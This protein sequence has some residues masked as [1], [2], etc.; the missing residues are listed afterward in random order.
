MQRKN[1]MKKQRGSHRGR[2]WTSCIKQKSHS[3]EECLMLHFAGK[4]QGDC[5]DVPSPRLLSAL[6]VLDP[7]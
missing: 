3:L 7:N 5:R 6:V 4:Q 2:M 1:W